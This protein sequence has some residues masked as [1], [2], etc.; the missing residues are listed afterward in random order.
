MSE[1]T[2]SGIMYGLMIVGFLALWIWAWSSKR[3]PDFDEMSRLPLED[4]NEPSI[5][6]RNTAQK[7]DQNQQDK[8]QQHNE[9]GQQ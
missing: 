4:V 3:K 5:D 9:R 7:T 6:Q 1:Y 2:Y 8:S